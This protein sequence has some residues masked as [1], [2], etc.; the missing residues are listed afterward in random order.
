MEI[1]PPA[2]QSQGLDLAYR[3]RCEY[4]TVLSKRTPRPN[5]SGCDRQMLLRTRQRDLAL[6]Y[7]RI[8]QAYRRQFAESYCWAT[9]TSSLT[10][11]VV[12]DVAISV[13]VESL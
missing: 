9:E 4:R 7:V 1:P 3:E 5:E 2:F 13:P 6:S 10:M 11:I 12:D 8:L